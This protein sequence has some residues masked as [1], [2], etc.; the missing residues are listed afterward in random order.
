MDLGIRLILAVICLIWD[1]PY[2]YAI[3]T[4][5]KKA[6]KQK[7]YVK[8]KIPLQKNCVSDDRYITYST[9]PQNKVFKT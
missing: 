3:R 4:K 9:L 8:G 1:K 6:R 2:I 7:N 5:K